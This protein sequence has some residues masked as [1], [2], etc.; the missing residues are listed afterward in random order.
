VLVDAD[1]AALG[2][3]IGDRARAAML[4][5]LLGGGSM[6]AGELARTADISASG[7]S[8]HLRKLRDA[9]LIVEE[10][11]GRNRFFTLASPELAE[12][13]ESLARVAPPHRPRNLRQSELGRALKRSRTCYDH[14]AGELG[15]A[16]TD[17]LLER[18]LLKQLAD[19]FA[20][21][22][23]A[24]SWFSTIGIDTELLERRR[25]AVAR[26]CIDWTER[27]PHL[28]GSL[29]EALVAT[30]LAKRWIRRIP[31]GRAV[32]VTPSG[33]RWLDQELGIQT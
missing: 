20:L 18:R 26:S 28:A 11:A 19:G 1:I 22:A 27:R 10:A 13:L 30:F 24:P 12:T 33:A 8:M 17:A 9:G 25:R 32:A 31:G 21:T 14:L 5:R 4:L 23:A 15:V 29:G 2:K 7:A 6:T 3:L 16:V